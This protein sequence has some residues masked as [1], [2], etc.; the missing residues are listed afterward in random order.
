MLEMALCSVGFGL[1][2][3]EY[4]LKIEM[5]LMVLKLLL[6]MA[7]FLVGLLMMVVRGGLMFA[8]VPDC[9]TSR[10]SSS[11]GLIS[12]TRDSHKRIGLD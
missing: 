3:L 9:L 10:R 8:L 4:Y 2:A 6:L 11:L 7:C 1:S 5:M 12:Q